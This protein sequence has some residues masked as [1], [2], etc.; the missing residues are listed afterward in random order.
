MNK[1]EICKEKHISLDK[2]H[3]QSKKYNGS[4]NNYN[5]ANVCPN[6]HRKIHKGKIILEGKFNSTAGLMLVWR[7]ENQ[8]KIVP[9]VNDPK[10]Y[11]M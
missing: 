7:Y 4:N 3:I 6:C 10:V 8:N 1:C 5:I 11:L 2:H 9:N